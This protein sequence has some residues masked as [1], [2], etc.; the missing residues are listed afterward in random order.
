MATNLTGLTT[1]ASRV[2]P[3][4]PTTGRP[5][6]TLPALCIYTT[7]EEAIP[8]LAT[9]DGSVRKEARELTLVIEGYAED[10]DGLD[11]TLDD[12]AAE[13]EA[14]MAGDESI[15]SLAEESSFRE[16]EIEFDAEAEAP[17]G[18]VRLTYGVLYR[19][20]PEDPETALS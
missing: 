8:E 15:N 10:T 3:S 2:H 19:V 13:V 18:I 17:H 7:A 5:L 6:A 20:N 12:I 16:T 14:A 9:Y 4:R 11:D 1:T